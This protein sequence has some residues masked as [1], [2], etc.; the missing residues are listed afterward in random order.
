MVGQPRVPGPVSWRG[1][2]RMVARPYRSV[3][4]GACLAVFDSNVPRFFRSEERGEFASYLRALPGPYVVLRMEDREV[5]ACGGYAVREEAAVGD[6]CW[7]MV[8]RDLHGLGLGRALARLRLG[9]LRADPRARR[10]ELNTSQ[11]TVGFYEA[12]GFRT[13]AVQ[14]DGYGPGLDRCQMRLSFGEGGS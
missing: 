10:V 5:V 8:R 11:H 4:L 1:D 13:L 6:L 12:M 7:G 3:D 14:P 9:A 2:R